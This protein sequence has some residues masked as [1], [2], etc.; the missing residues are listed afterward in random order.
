MVLV[1]SYPRYCSG[2]HWSVW[3]A[4]RS[5]CCCCPASWWWT[6]ASWS[7]LVGRGE[8]PW[9]ED[10]LDFASLLVIRMIW[11]WA[12]SSPS[13][14]AALRLAWLAF[15][16]WV[17]LCTLYISLIYVSLAVL[18]VARYSARLA[19]TYLKMKN[20]G[21]NPFSHLYLRYLVHLVPR[22][23]DQNQGCHDAVGWGG[24]GPASL[25]VVHAVIWHLFVVKQIS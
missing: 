7:P 12:S 1:D 10:E 13:P 17:S 14:S 19:K 21:F 22:Q 11:G 25:Y 24:Q 15:K 16:L 23:E 3:S 8:N 6:V 18:I 2:D 20:F 5:G 9:C 4:S